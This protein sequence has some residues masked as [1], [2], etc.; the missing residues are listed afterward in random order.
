V[1]VWRVMDVHE[2]LQR[3]EAWEAGLRVDGVFLRRLKVRSMNAR[4]VEI[5]V[6]ETILS[7]NGKRKRSAWTWKVWRNELKHELVW[8]RKSKEEAIERVEAVLKNHKIREE[9]LHELLAV[10]KHGRE[11]GV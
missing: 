8:C 6:D 2:F 9:K 11:G 10:L 7:M 1:G 4:M 3:G 5:D